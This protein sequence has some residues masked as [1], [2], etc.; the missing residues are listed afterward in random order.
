MT[1][2]QSTTQ[3]L[4]FA[5]GSIDHIYTDPPYLRSF[6]DCYR[7]LANEAARVLKPGGF[8]MAMLGGSY[9][10]Q[11]F[12]FFDEAGL[13][14]YWDYSFRMPGAK[15]GIVWKHEAGGNKPIIIRTKSVLVYSK[16]PS[17]S[18]TGTA[19]LID[20]LDSGQNWKRFHRW[21]QSAA[22][23]RYYLD[24]FTAEGDL[25]CDPF[26]GG[27][28]TAL[29]ATMTNRRFV[30]CDLDPLA[31]RASLAN[32]NGDAVAMPADSLFAGVE[33]GNGSRTYMEMPL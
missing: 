23:A 28:S 16:G 13:T 10:N 29:A 4:P 25:I 1:L 22:V 30:G 8:V 7:W 11:I 3:R 26:L 32:I 33:V 6:L 9:K 5:D 15:S 31:L 20:A 14:Y 17:I 12:K 27:G 18:R 19:D 2:I 21:G 24:C